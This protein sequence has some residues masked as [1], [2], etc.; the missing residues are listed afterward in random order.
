MT[1]REITRHEYTCDSCGD[2]EDEEVE[3]M[4]LG[5]IQEGDEHFC[6]RCA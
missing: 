2:V 6:A 4:P 5:W 3:G 1:Y